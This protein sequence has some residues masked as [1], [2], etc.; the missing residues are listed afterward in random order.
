MTKH[1]LRLITTIIITVI[2]SGILFSQSN[3]TSAELFTIPW[4]EGEGEISLD[5][6]IELPPES[7]D[8]RWPPWPIAVS[9]SGGIVIVNDHDSSCLTKY[10][11]NGNYIA[12]VN[13]YNLNI[14]R[15]NYIAI[16]E[17]GDVLCSDLQKLYYFDECL[18]HVWSVIMDD[19]SDFY[20][21]ISIHGVYPCEDGN[22]WCIYLHTSKSTIRAELVKVFIDS[23]LSEPELLYECPNVSPFPIRFDY[24]S[25]CG[26]IYNWYAVDMYG[27]SYMQELQWQT[28]N[29]LTKRNS[30]GE[31]IY[32]N[33]ISN[34][35]DCVGM[36]EY[37]VMWSGN[38]FTVHGSEEGMVV[39]KY[40]LQQ[41]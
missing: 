23:T 8:M 7:E 22:F 36:P 31:V 21:R 41:E 40:T 25:P 33:L 34:D 2:S 16:S 29:T 4:G 13:L 15:P 37:F 27:Y 17:T 35:P 32:S 10:S 18:Q 5:W 11:I 30:E 24:V 1:I 6:S 39:T 19:N 26:D 9:E 3:Y 12:Q 14:K 20:N 38:Y 28:P